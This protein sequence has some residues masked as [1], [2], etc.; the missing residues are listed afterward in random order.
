VAEP[1]TKA[2]LEAEADGREAPSREEVEEHAAKFFD[3]FFAM[4]FIE[5]VHAIRK[6]IP[7]TGEAERIAVREGSASQEVVERTFPLLPGSHLEL[8]DPALEFAK[9]VCH[10]A[11][12]EPAVETQ[13]LR[14]RRNILRQLD[15]REF[16]LEGVWQNPSL[17]FV[18]PEVVCDFCGHCRDLDVCRDGDWAC[19][20]PEC[21]NPYDHE[22]IETRLVALVKRRSHAY[23]LQDVQCAKC[24]LVKSKNI[25]PFCTKC[26]GPFALR[27]S[28]DGFLSNLRTFANVAAYHEM[29]LLAETTDFL[30]HSS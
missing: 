3:E 22:A 13:L 23:Q 29:P 9:A 30:L 1:W 28:R 11:S 16:A 20:Q 19:D 10:L 8:A 5:E 12:L 18:L 25:A 2:A 14:L 26:A 15:V 27:T 21:R 6:A 7:S 17:S 4:R 24:R